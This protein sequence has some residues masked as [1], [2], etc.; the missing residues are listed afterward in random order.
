MIGNHSIR[1]Y[2]AMMTQGSTNQTLLTLCI[3]VRER[4]MAQGALGRAPLSVIDRLSQD[5]AEK[6]KKYR[7]KI[8]SADTRGGTTTYYEPSN[9]VEAI[10]PFGARSLG[11]TG[12]L[13]TLV[14]FFK[15]LKQ[16]TW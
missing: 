16:T 14:F 12:V 15:Y 3:S 11:S 2:V 5:I 1:F 13:T 6:V 4:Q 7:T 9:S 10:F 8:T